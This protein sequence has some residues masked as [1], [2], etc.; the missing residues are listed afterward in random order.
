MPGTIRK[1]ILTGDEMN[2]VDAIALVVGEEQPAIGVGARFSTDKT[3][4]K[5]TEEKIT[6][7]M[8]L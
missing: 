4:G 2:N 3:V 5:I 1:W 7:L 6:D 8:L